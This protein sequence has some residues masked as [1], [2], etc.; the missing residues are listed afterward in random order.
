MSNNV[1]MF[2]VIHAHVLVIIHV[3]WD[4]V[5]HRLL[6]SQEI[7]ITFCKDRFTLSVE[8]SVLFHS[9]ILYFC[10]CSCAKR[11]RLMIM[12]ATTLHVLTV[13][14]GWLIGISLSSSQNTKFSFIPWVWW[15]NWWCLRQM[16]G[17]DGMQQRNRSLFT[18]SKWTN[19]MSRS[20]LSVRIVGTQ[21]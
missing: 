2:A 11:A 14:R 19:F 4:F 8:H 9:L 13:L 16:E 5:W 12:K 6:S 18:T 10:C 17:T 7:N 15:C 20:T 1:W 21:C 3:I